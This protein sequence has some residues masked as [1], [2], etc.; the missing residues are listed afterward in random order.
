MSDVDGLFA[1]IGAANLQ[2]AMGETIVQ[3]VQGN[4]ANQVSLENVIV[5]VSDQGETPV[6][7]PTGSMVVRWGILLIPATVT[8]NDAERKQQRD[9]FLVRGKLWDCERV[10]GQGLSLQTV[11]I[12]REERASSKRTHFNT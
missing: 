4:S 1:E 8:I 2:S 11:R 6:D 3:Y 7:G 12:K 9:Q 5:D 10:T